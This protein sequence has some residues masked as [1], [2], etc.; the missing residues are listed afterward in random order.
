M[1]YTLAINAQ[2][3]IKSTSKIEISSPEIGI[4]S[5]PSKINNYYSIEEIFYWRKNC[6]EISLEE[7]EELKNI[8]TQKTSYTFLSIYKREHFVG[9]RF[10]G[11]DFDPNHSAGRNSSSN[12]NKFN[13]IRIGLSFMVDIDSR[14]SMSPIS[15]SYYFIDFEFYFNYL[16]LPATARG[17]R[18]MNNRKNSF[19]LSVLATPTQRFYAFMKYKPVGNT[20]IGFYFKQNRHF[21]GNDAKNSW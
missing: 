7:Q 4:N 12:F 18:Q 17:D 13:K 16:H 5:K 1:L 9:L 10:W 15:D 2:L 21:Y 11:F 14:Y 8:F 3:I 19:M 20:W 6:K